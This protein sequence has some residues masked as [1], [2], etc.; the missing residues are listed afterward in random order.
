MTTPAANRRIPTASQVLARQKA[1]A[2]RELAQKKA[3]AAAKLAANSSSTPAPAKSTAVAPAAKTAVAVRDNRSSVQKYLDEIAP[4]T[5]VGRRMK[6]DNK[7][8]RY[9]MPDNDETVAETAE[10][11]ALCDQTAAGYLKFNGKGNPP[12]SI[13]GLIYEGFEVPARD[14]LS[15]RDESTWPIGL[16]DEPED[17]WQHRQYLVLQNTETSELF[18]FDA[19][20]KTSWRAVANLLRHYERMRRTNPDE[21]PVVRLKTGGF[22]HKEERV[23]WVSV[24][25]FAIIGRV[26]RDSAT[27][28][29]T[30]LGGDLDDE[31][32]FN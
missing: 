21:Y 11:I 6:F 14:E 32:P 4:A 26:P 23:G 13:M 29:D 2:E 5:I 28:P 15:D 19:A 31:I 9:F 30:S 8:S 22:P 7:T 3:A 17:P 18:T 20:N 10:F 16:S 25:V 12:D 1:D 27:K 24:P